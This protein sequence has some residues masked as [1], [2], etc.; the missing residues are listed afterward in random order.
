MNQ[1]VDHV[2][3]FLAACVLA[4]SLW[5]AGPSSASAQTQ[6][7]DPGY[8]RD[9]VSLS[10]VIGRAHAIRIRCNGRGD[11]HWRGFMR[12]LLELEAPE[13]TTLRRSMVNA[14]NDSYSDELQTR[15]RCNE[16]AREAEAR[17][18]AEGRVLADRL[19]TY[20][21]PKPTQGN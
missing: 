19:A 7:R 13:A 6:L 18:A 10:G 11:Q 14:F 15:G 3:P 9:V 1:K 2:R 4:A 12:E 20:F 5:T 8:L 16:T 17:Y 21:F